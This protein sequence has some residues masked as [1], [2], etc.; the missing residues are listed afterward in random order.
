VSRF[1]P[2]NRT[3]QRTN[4]RRMPRTLDDVRQRAKVV[5]QPDH[6]RD[7]YAGGSPHDPPCKPGTCTQCAKWRYAPMH[8]LPEAP[9][10]V[11]EPFRENI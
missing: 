3:Q 7:P 5:Y 1:P 6:V 9:P 2:R 10:F 4:L 8:G 11:P